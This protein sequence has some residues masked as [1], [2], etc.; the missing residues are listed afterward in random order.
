MEKANTEKPKKIIYALDIPGVIDVINDQGK[1]RYLMTDNKLTDQIELDDM[2]CAPPPLEAC[3][4]TFAD[5]EGLSQALS[6]HA[7]QECTEDIRLYEDLL[8]YHKHISDLPHELYYHLLVLWDFHTYILDKLHFSPILYFYAVKERGKSRTMKGALYVARRGV[9]TECIRE[10]DIIRWGNDHKASLGFDIKDFPKKVERANCD[11]LF[12][13]RF[14]KGSVSSRTL[15]P[16]K[17]AFK[18]TKVY[19]LFGPTIIATNRPVDDIL[20]SRS[21]AVDMKPSN[22]SFSNKVLPEYAQPLKDRLTAFRI[23]HIATPL[24]AAEKPAQGRFGDIMSPLYQLVLTFFPEKKE[25][26]LRLIALIDTQKKE[27][28]IDSIEA[29]VLEALIALKYDVCDAFLPTDLVANKINATRDTRFTLTHETIGRIL[30]GLGFLK[31]RGTQGQRGILYDEELLTKLAMSYGLL[32]TSD[33]SDSEKTYP[34]ADNESTDEKDTCEVMCEENPSEVSEPSIQ[35]LFDNEEDIPLP[36]S[37][38]PKTI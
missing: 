12:L 31:K 38:S 16:E 19:H 11:D 3:P 9:Y 15:W 36:V 1:L 26:F 30:K 28:A 35:K 27:D 2:I 13:A 33:S 4:Y 21:I 8:A 22:K 34:E 7:E 17:G 10:A 25:T 23:A 6:H 18:D 5:K 20:E 24:V 29:H 37:S 32:G 14:E